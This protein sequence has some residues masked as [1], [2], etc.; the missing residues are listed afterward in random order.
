M[1]RSA[2]Y[3]TLILCFSS[4]SLL[5]QSSGYL[6]KRNSAQIN[7]NLFPT[8]TRKTELLDNQVIQSKRFFHYSFQASFNHTFGRK[9][10]ITLAYQMAKVNGESRNFKVYNAPYYG[11]TLLQDINYNYQGFSLGFNF[12]RKGSLSP[13][14]KYISLIIDYGVSKID[15]FPILLGSQ[16]GIVE[17]NFFKTV[18]NSSGHIEENVDGTTVKSYGLRYQVGRNF[19]INKFMFIHSSISIPLLY[20]LSSSYETNASFN[21]G[22]VSSPLNFESYAAWEDYHKYAVQ[23]ISRLKIELGLRICF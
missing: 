13:I 5:S 16:Y 19:P 15:S 9:F 18:Y 10:E 11:A 20:I 8:T 6:G 14:G 4:I 1:F 22:N 23:K 3:I 12:Y 17:T 21:V 7:V 2:L